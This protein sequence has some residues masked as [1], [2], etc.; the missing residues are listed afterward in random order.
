VGRPHLHTVRV[1]YAEADLQGIAFNA[2]YLAYF[3]V[4][5]V[6][7]WRSAF[8]GYRRMLDR[9]VDVVLAEARLQFRKPARF[10]DEL[11]LAITVARLGTTSMISRHTASC[12]GELLVVG[13]LRHVFV[14]LATLVKTPV[15][16]WARVG[17]EPWIVP[18]DDLGA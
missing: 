2:H 14:D 15:P 7:L 10:D 5:M 1:R 4:S 8:G 13:E 18:D 3:D 12:A 11:T 17:L 16:D 9:G 6:E